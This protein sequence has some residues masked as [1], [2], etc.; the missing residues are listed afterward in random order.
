MRLKHYVRECVSGC[1]ATLVS[2][3]LVL[4]VGAVYGQERGA[5]RLLQNTNQPA[6]TLD[7]SEDRSEANR[8]RRDRQEL[9]AAAPQSE[10]ELNRENAEHRRQSARIQRELESLKARLNELVAAGKDDEAA[11]IKEQIVR[12]EREVEKFRHE[13]GEL[14]REGRPD[15][16]PREERPERFQREPM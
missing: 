7:R 5:E 3:V 13:R 2:A 6:P 12:R 4:L 15:R 14:R 16:A 1:T 11:A 9:R 8:G 10:A